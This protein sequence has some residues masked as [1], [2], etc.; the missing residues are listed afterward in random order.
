MPRISGIDI[1]PDKKI[2]ISLRYIY[3]VGP[4]NA[5]AILKEAGIDPERRA[6][7]LSEEELAKII[8][9]DPAFA[10][11]MA[12]K[13]YTYALGR[14]LEL[15]DPNH[16]DVPALAAVSSAFATKGLKFQDLVAGIVSSPT[17]LNRRGDGG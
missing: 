8:G 1:P 14:G 4:T 13:L 6:K 11:C 7:E 9:S 3:G 17:F 12:T 2:R 10:K 15:S 16:M 5:V